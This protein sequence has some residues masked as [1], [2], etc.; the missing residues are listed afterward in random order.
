MK[1]FAVECH[2]IHHAYLDVLSVFGN[3]GDGLLVILL[4]NQDGLALARLHLLEGVEA[5]LV[6]TVP[7]HHL[8][9]NMI[10]HR[11]NNSLM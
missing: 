3:E 6:H 11:L 5:L 2:F 1:H 7:H 4:A 8:G 10:V 9:E